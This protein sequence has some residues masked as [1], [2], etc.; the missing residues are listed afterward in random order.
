M[1]SNEDKFCLITRKILD[2]YP[3]IAKLADEL[4][5]DPI[6]YLTYKVNYDAIIEGSIEE[7]LKETREL[8]DE[9]YMISYCQVQRYQKLFEKKKK[10]EKN[11]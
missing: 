1:S 5:E 4:I 10:K 3:I 8:L 6:P 11:D 7:N 9:I 2:I